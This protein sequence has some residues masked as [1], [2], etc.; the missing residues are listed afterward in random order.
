MKK[1][2]VGHLWLT[3]WVIPLVILFMSLGANSTN[4]GLN[5]NLRISKNSWS[6]LLTGFRCWRLQ[7]LSLGGLD[8]KI[9]RRLKGRIR[10]RLWEIQT[11]MFIR[12]PVR[13]RYRKPRWCGRTPW[14]ITAT[15]ATAVVELPI[16]DRVTISI[17]HSESYLCKTQDQWLLFRDIKCGTII[18]ASS[19][20]LLT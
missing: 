15:S 19:K 13:F 3:L 2:A 18:I 5:L 10:V 12:M 1:I 6:F 20:V 7:L 4:I 17:I 8:L 11:T 9:R 14:N 16:S